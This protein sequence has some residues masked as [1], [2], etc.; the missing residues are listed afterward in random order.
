MGV[1]MAKCKETCGT[2]GFK[3]ALSCPEY[4]IPKETEADRVA[5]ENAQYRFK[6]SNQEEYWDTYFATRETYQL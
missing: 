1:F 5:F 6:H 4:K 2:C 3:K